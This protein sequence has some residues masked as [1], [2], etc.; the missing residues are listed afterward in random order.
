VEP[1][2]VPYDDDLR[3]AVKFGESPEEDWAA[4]VSTV[5]S[6]NT[7]AQAAFKKAQKKYLKQIRAWK[8]ERVAHEH[9][10]EAAVEAHKAATA[11]QTSAYDELHEAW[12]SEYREIS[13]FWLKDIGIIYGDTSKAAPR[14][15]NGYPMLMGCSLLNPSD[16]ERVRVAVNREWDR[17]KEIDV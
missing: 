17:Q 5:D 13:K 8:A 3:I 15:I 1:A 6:Q 7:Q 12:M 2:L 10:F 11:A 4:H 9:E 16:W 14:V